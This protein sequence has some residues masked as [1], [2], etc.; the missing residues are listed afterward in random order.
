M[1]LPGIEVGDLGTKLG[2]NAIDNGYL[3]FDHFRIPRKALLSRFMNINKKG[4]FKMKANPKIIYQ[5][6]V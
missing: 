4:E 1:P 5:I 3:K 2:Y 6:M